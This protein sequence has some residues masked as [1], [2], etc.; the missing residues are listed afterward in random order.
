MNL[1]MFGKLIA[2]RYYTNE[3]NYFI[4]LELIKWLIFK[5]DLYKDIYEYFF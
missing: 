2:R 5:N 1:K 4:I 3:E